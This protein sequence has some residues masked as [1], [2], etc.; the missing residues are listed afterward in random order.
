MREPRNDGY[1]LCILSDTWVYATLPSAKRLKSLDI[2]RLCPISKIGLYR[3]P[4]MPLLQSGKCAR[5]KLQSLPQDNPSP[6]APLPP[7]LAHLLIRQ[8]A[9]IF[10]P[11]LASPR[12]PSGSYPSSQRTSATSPQRSFLHNI[13]PHEKHDNPS[14]DFDRQ[15]R[16]RKHHQ[17][18]PHHPPPIPSPIISVLSRQLSIRFHRLRKG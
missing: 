9:A 12:V 15:D 3:Y 2:H 14:T 1:L 11:H 5:E 10:K 17:Q 4:V 8:Q 6:P 7:R 16:K 18:A 13:I